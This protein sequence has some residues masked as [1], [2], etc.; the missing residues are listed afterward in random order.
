VAKDSQP[1][2]QQYDEPYDPRSTDLMQPDP[3]A[4]D[5]PTAPEVE[6]SGP[7]TE[8]GRILQEE[9]RRTG[10]LQRMLA[11]R[12][13]ISQPNVSAYERG[14]MQPSWPIF[15][16]LLAAMERRPVL[17]TAPLEPEYL[18]KVTLAEVIDVTL[19]LVGDRSYRFEDEFAAHLLGSD[20][21]I[22]Y[23][24][25]AMVADPDRLD[26]FALEVV[27]KLGGTATTKR[28]QRLVPQVQFHHG[29]A[30]YVFELIAEGRRF[31]QVSHDGRTVNVSPAQDIPYPW[32]P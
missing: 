24:H 23:V 1:S 30:M 27:R 14:R 21:P 4:A 2:D 6:T 29:T 12:T 22:G 20:W 11:Q 31:V 8:L 7:A 25:V 10:T 32:R 26:E 16:R 18:P 19:D 5:P 28:G 9:R 15:V 13:G 3:V 17:E